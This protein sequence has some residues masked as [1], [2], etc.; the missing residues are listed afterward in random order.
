[1][2]PH[3]ADCVCDDCVA[4]LLRW[5]ETQADAAFD[6]LAKYCPHEPTDRQRAFLALL[7]LE[8]LYGGSAGSGKSDA[9]LMAAL[10]YVHVPGYSALILRR[11]FR[12]LEGADG[13]VARS[14]EWLGGTDAKWSASKMFWAFPSGAT[15]RF[16]HIQHETDKT[17][18]QGHA[19]QFVGY[20]ET[21]H[22]TETMWTYLL[23][24]IRRPEVGP[25]AMVPL[26]IRGA[27]NPG[28]VGHAWVQK[29]FGIRTD[30]TQDR[31]AATNAETGEVCEFVAAKLADNPHLDQASYRRNFARVDSTT[32]DQLEHGKWV[33]DGQGLVYR[34]EESRNVISLRDWEALRAKPGWHDVLAL[35]LG[36]TEAKPTT[37]FVRLSWSDFDHR[38]VVT[39]SYKLAGMTPSSDAECI[40][41]ERAER[42][43][44]WVVYDAG[45]L[46]SAYGREFA[47]R[48]GEAMIQAAKKTDKLG[49]RRLMNGALERGHLLIV[50][51]QNDDLFEELGTL[52]WNEAGTDNERGFDNHA[53]DALLYGWRS[54]LGFAAEPPATEPA[55][56]AP[57]WGALEEQ[58]MEQAAAVECRKSSELTWLGDEVDYDPTEPEWWEQDA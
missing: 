7:C 32:R 20:D 53:T 4:A 3:P 23:T 16:G 36:A 12:Q 47:A 1:M 26:R 25:L 24:R 45:A 49:H 14:Q 34:F 11:T 46:G 31:G 42:E 38:V 6:P 29:R 40:A 37:A 51:E 5:V 18:Y 48:F 22:F 44:D 9:L 27:T 41:K 17:D 13:L 56:G 57:E 50:D 10:Q 30:G 58:R 21:T 28:G 8:A 19:L 33:R 52:P 43:I 35:D 55:Q 54:A 39:K 15:L 2:T